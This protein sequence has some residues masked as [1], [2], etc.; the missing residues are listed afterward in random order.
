[1]GSW[2]PSAE[3]LGSSLCCSDQPLW[4]AGSQETRELST[5]GLQ[6]SHLV[7][8][9]L[10]PPY[11]GGLGSAQLS[12]PP[13][14]A[15]AGPSS[16]ALGPGAQGLLHLGPAQPSGGRGAGMTHQCCGEG[17]TL[18]GGPRGGV[19]PCGPLP[20]GSHWPS[21]W[22][23]PPLL[24]D[25]EEAPTVQNTS[26]CPSR[27]CPMFSPYSVPGMPAPDLEGSGSWTSLPSGI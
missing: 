16:H 18:P 20:G 5:R 23:H 13:L 7:S 26:G 17:R 10:G 11:S 12:T 14:P 3:T 27:P 1:M 8:L 22:L 24:A 25:P 6:Q 4:E 2:G 9:Q 19:P 15:W 21:P